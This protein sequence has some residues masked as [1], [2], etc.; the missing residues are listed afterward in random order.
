MNARYGGHPPASVRRH[1]DPQRMPGVV[2]TTL[3]DRRGVFGPR[4]NGPTYDRMQWG[5]AMGTPGKRPGVTLASRRHAGGVGT[6]GP[7]SGTT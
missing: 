7:W 4:G 5:A 3:S 2:P 6:S 1:G